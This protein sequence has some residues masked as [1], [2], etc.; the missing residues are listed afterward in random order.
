[1]DDAF[2]RQTTSDYSKELKSWLGFRR[3][4]RV[5]C[6]GFMTE[7]RYSEDIYSYREIHDPL[8]N[9][10]KEDHYEPDKD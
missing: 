8:T 1:M 10:V 3:C 5:N 6:N 4:I 7:G 2:A 9:R